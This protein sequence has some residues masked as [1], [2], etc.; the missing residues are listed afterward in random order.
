MPQ[1]VLSLNPNPLR[2]RVLTTPILSRPPVFIIR[3]LVQ[4]HSLS[5][6]QLCGQVEVEVRHGGYDLVSFQQRAV[7]TAERNH[8]FR[9]TPRP[10]QSRCMLLVPA[11]S[12]LSTSGINAPSLTYQAAPKCRYKRASAMVP[13]LVC[14]HH[15]NAEDNTTHYRILVLCHLLPTTCS[16]GFLNHRGTATLPTGLPRAITA[17]KTR[18][19]TSAYKS[20]GHHQPR[21]PSMGH[22]DKADNAG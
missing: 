21:A 18:T 8:S 16:S 9:L 7:G 10:G 11:T 1:L 17:N 20:P 12:V 6:C 22:H 19:G 5:N 13:P 2:Q 4:H 14:Q 15:G 3:G